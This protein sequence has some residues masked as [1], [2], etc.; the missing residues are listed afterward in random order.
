MAEVTTTKKQI[1]T[2]LSHQQVTLSAQQTTAVFYA[3]VWNDSDRFASF[4]VKL[5]AAGMTLEASKA[6]YRLTPA[7]SSKIPIGDSTRFQIEVFDLPPIAQ[8]FRGAID[9]TVEVTSRDLENQYDR[10]PLRLL[11]EGIQ[12]APPSLGFTAPSFQALPGE[13]VPITAQIHNSTGVPQAVTLRLSGLP[14]LWFPDGVQQTH[15]LPSGKPQPIQFECVV[16]AAIQAPS[17]LYALQLEATGRFPTVITIGQFQVLPSGQIEFACTPLEGAIPEVL[18]RW[19]NPTWGATTFTLQFHNQSNIQPGVQVSVQELQPPRRWFWQKSSSLETTS[20]PLVLP[21]GVSLGEPIAALPP[22]P[23]SLPLTI[24]RRLPWLGWARLR[25]FEVTAHSSTSTIP[26][27]NQTHQLKVHLFPVMPFW[28]QVLGILLALGLG[29]LVWM[30]LSAP[31]HRG[32]VTSVQFNGQGTEV[33]S[34]SEDQTVLRWQ[35]RLEHLR[36]RSRFSDFGRAVRVARYRP[37][38]NDQVALGFENGEIRIVNLLT[39]KESQLTPDKDDRVFALV[40]SHNARTLYSG[41]GS[42]LMLQWDISQFEPEQTTPQQ[43]YKI[44]FP[45][46]AMT[47]VGREDKYLAIGGQHNHLALLNV[48]PIIVKGSNTLLN[49]PYSNGSDGEN[50]DVTSL[51]AAAEQPNLLAV[52]DTRGYIS[53]W[54]T[55]S[56]L[57]TQGSCTPLKNHWLGHSGSSVRAVALSASGCF[58]AS[59]AD[60]GQVKLWPLKGIGSSFALEERVLEHGSQPMKAVD[61]IETRHDVWVASGSNDGRVRLHQVPIAS[62]N[63]QENRCPA[64]AE[65]PS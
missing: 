17:D 8:Q 65:D 12:G 60:N 28:L 51:S 29:S 1:I 21:E 14:D 47:L 41:H 46:Q 25:R 39:G 26:I 9:L 45:I 4:Q 19:Q 55:Q 44:P 59:A 18:G 22:G 2:E 40:F 43:A 23:S 15:T 64:L 49:L 13:R 56:C 11:V 62:K 33:L 31:G 54:D 42:G 58:L 27:Q 5:L 10:Q 52:A 37:V 38:N 36:Q 61:V 50:A 6:W 24:Q 32:P 57:Q 16:P 7:V 34:G 63:R 3:T 48:D 35:M 30:L 53:L 20:D